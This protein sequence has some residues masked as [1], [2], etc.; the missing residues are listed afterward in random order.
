MNTYVLGRGRL[1][2]MYC[3]SFWVFDEH[4]LYISGGRPGRK[5]LSEEKA[6]LI[7][8]GKKYIERI[9]RELEEAQDALVRAYSVQVYDAET[10]KKILNGRT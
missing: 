5:F 4:G 10:E 8:D 7:R 9:K 1:S 6:E 2:G 3:E